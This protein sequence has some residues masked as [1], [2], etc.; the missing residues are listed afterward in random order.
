MEKKGRKEMGGNG[1]RR[2]RGKEKWKVVDK[3]GRQMRTYSTGKVGGEW[4][5]RK[6]EGLANKASAPSPLDR[7]SGSA[8][9]GLTPSPL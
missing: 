2:E 7:W 6:W 4:E 3:G 5:G 1:R 8:T 9:D